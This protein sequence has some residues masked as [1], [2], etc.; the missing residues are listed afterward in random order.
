MDRLILFVYF[1]IGSHSIVSGQNIDVQQYNYSIRL[2]DNKDEI[3]GHATIDIEFLE[4]ATSFSLD[5]MNEKNG[6]GMKVSDVNA[7]MALTNFTHQDDKLSFNLKWPALKGDKIRVHVI[8]RGV[9]ADGLIISK[10][11]HGERTFF[12]DNWPNRARHWIPCNDHP[13]DKSAV[14]FYVTVPKAYQVISNGEVPIDTFGTYGESK[15]HLYH[16][17]E[18]IPIPTK[19]MVIGAAR[20]AV[21]EYKDSPEGIPVSAWTYPQDSTKGFYDYALA[22]PILNFFTEYIGPYPYKKLANVQSKTIFGGME[23]AGC[24]FYSE[25]SVTGTRSAE[26]LIAHEIV[27]QWFGNSATEKHFS[28]LW[29]SEGFAT[30]LTNVYLEHKYGRDTVLKR[31]RADRTKVI[32][33]LKKNPLPVVD[34]TSALMALLNANSYQKGGWVLRMIQDEVGDSVFQQIIRRYYSTYK[35]SNAETRDFQKV[36]EDVTGKSWKAFFD[37]WLYR[38]NIPKIGITWAQKKNKL[39]VVLSQN[40]GYDVGVEYRIVMEDGRSFIKTA[41][42]F[43]VI[44]VTSRIPGKVKEIIPDPD[45]KLLS[46]FTTKRDQSILKKWPVNR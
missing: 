20:F 8:Y 16:W 29:L 5:L 44:T 31:L 19:V 43:Q 45:V 25:S 35:F 12:A 24:I 10:S 41:S 34:S 22:V 14:E 3:E 33:F 40:T 37:Q 18:T 4:Y 21:K 1:L 36:V 32:E 42:K 26:A 28:H 13:Y 6:K 23:N 2:F 7:S 11:K 9:P 17:K 27:H 30:H 39:V 46:D 15:F 38:K